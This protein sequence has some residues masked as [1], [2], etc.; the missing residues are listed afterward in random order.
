MFRGHATPERTPTRLELIFRSA[1]GNSASTSEIKK[2]DCSSIPKIWDFVP[3][4]WN[5]VPKFWEIPKFQKIRASFQLLRAAINA[6]LRGEHPTVFQNEWMVVIITSLAKQQTALQLYRIPVCC[7]HL[8]KVTI[9]IN[10]I[11]KRMSSFMASSCPD[12]VMK[13]GIFMELHELLENVQ[14]AFCLL[15]IC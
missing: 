10:I 4:N 11:Y 14:E 15:Y 12:H 8:H 13:R 1:N 5:L 2:R 9:L 6:F 3:K 7:K